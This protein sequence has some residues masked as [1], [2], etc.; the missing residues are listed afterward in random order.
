M[1]LGTTSRSLLKAAT[2]KFPGGSNADLKKYVHLQVEAALT[3]TS[4][5]TTD[6]TLFAR[7]DEAFEAA[8]ADGEGWAIRLK[9]S[10]RDAQV[11]PLVEKARKAGVDPIAIVVV[12]TGLSKED[13]EKMIEELDAMAADSDSGSD[14]DTGVDDA[15][16]STDDDSPTYAA[17]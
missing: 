13:A 14:S 2:T 5:G 6:E 7:A 12:E 1:S 16:A 9:D 10:F 11:K 3:H 4:R 8:V 17:A 15:T